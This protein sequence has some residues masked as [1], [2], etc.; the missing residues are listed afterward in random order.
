MASTVHRVPRRLQPTIGR[1]FVGGLLALVGLI[2]V[3]SIVVG[4][5]LLLLA[6]SASLVSF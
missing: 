4:G 5:A 1:A 3:V 2:G 6:R